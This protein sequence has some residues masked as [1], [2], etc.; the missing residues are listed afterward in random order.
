[1]Y[2]EGRKLIEMRNSNHVFSNHNNIQLLRSGDDYFNTLL[3]SLRQAKYSIHLQ[4]YIFDCDKTGTLILEALTKA[5][6]R[7]VAVFVVVDGYAS[8]HFTPKQ[9]A[10]MK[11]VG[12]HVKLFAP[13][14]ITALKMGRRLHHKIVL[15][16]G[17]TAILGGINISDKYSG[18]HGHTPW[19]DVAVQVQG[20]VC[21]DIWQ[22]CIAVW[23]K[24]KQKKMKQEMVHL[25]SINQQVKLRLLQNDWW[26]RKIEISKAY[27]DAIR[28]CKE[29][30]I[31]VASYFLP[32]YRKRKLLQ[33]AVSRGV[34]V[35][36]VSGSMSDVPLIKSANN[37]LYAWMLKQGMTIYE[38]QPSVLHA[39]FA[40]ADNTWCTVGSYN[41]NALSDYGS[42]EANIEGCDK[43]F[44]KTTKQF[45]WQLI[46]E[47]CK[48]ID[49][50]DFL[51]HHTPM[52][53][54]YRW[55]CYQLMRL[56]LFVLFVLMKRDRLKL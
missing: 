26:R 23:P 7:G 6:A 19:L 34:K 4:V 24:R 47:G 42:L 11:E 5:T 41:L 17:E 8:P 30:L 21:K 1:M 3:H 20:E 51:R 46:A 38:W 28:T 10:Q 27:R 12:I 16:D 31:I 2:L 14:N 39:K 54:A 32:G 33:K 52:L 53:Q 45:V 48:K 22:L 29:E 18:W 15:I 25:N 55:C 44:N 43:E 13:L 36:L 9:I 37:F 56:G 50:E 35:I 49:A 40:I